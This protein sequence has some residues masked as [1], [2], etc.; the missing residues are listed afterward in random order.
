M[1][2]VLKRFVLDESCEFCVKVVRATFALLAD[3]L[4]AILVV[5]CARSLTYVVG[6]DVSLDAA[7]TTLT[8]VSFFTYGVW[9]IWDGIKSVARPTSPPCMTGQEP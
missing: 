4:I 6:A 9:G 5:I 7:H 2:M 8:I 1:A 3:L